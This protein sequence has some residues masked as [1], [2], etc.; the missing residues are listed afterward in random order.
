MIGDVVGRTLQAEV[1]RSRTVTFNPMRPDRRSDFS[2]RDFAQAAGMT[3]WQRGAADDLSRIGNRMRYR[4]QMPLMDGDQTRS[5]FP[6]SPE[7]SVETPTRQAARAVGVPQRFLDALI[8]QESG[9]N[10]DAKASTSSATGHAQ[11]IDSTWIRMMRQYGHR[12]GFGETQMNE[13]SEPELLALRRDPQW[14]AIMAAE[15]AREN[16]LALRG[17][18]GR[19]PRQHEVYLAHFLGSGDAVDI[20]RAAEQDRRRERGRARSAASVVSPA[21]AAANRSVFYTNGR[22]RTAAELIE[23]QGSKFS[24]DE[25]TVG[26]YAF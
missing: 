14:A 10:P 13:I 19:E 16:A 1:S 3:R 5:A 22:A 26:D 8:V 20:I 15:Y 6:F 23:L 12:Y 18:L 9:G 7:V 4:A 24:R 25:F 17:A 11:F 2:E 21:S